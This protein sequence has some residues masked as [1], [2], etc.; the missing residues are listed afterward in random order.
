M[1][2]LLRLFSLPLIVVASLAATTLA[3]NWLRFAGTLAVIVILSR[4]S[5]IY[6][7]RRFPKAGVEIASVFMALATTAVGFYLMFQLDAQVQRGFTRVAELAVN[8]WQIPV[9]YVVLTTLFV[10]MVSL[11]REPISRSGRP[12]LH[13]LLNIIGVG[14]VLF[15]LYWPAMVLGH[16][17]GAT[18]GL[19][20]AVILGMPPTVLGLLIERRLAR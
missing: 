4:G 11:T 2:K 18:A 13:A 16:Q 17:H 12:G 6:C 19:F 9:W 20:A 3:T 15:L 8:H 5:D 14:A 7:V 10:F 1:K